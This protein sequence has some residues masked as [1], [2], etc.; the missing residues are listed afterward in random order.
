MTK[1][2]HKRDHLK[3]KEKCGVVAVWTSSMHASYYARRASASLQHRGQ[4][5]AGMSVLNPTGKISTHKGMGLV[6]HV[7]TEDVL[8]KLGNGKAAIAQNRYGTFGKSSMETAQPIEIRYHKLHLVL[9]H[10]G[11]IPDVSNIRKK[12]DVGKKRQSDTA[13]IAFLI[14]K[15]RHKYTS[16]EETLIHVLP[17]FRGA[18]CLVILTNDGSLFGIRDPYGIRPLCLGRLKDGWII[19]SESA[20][21]DTIGAEFV[22]DVKPGEIIKIDAQGKLHSYFFGEPK[23]PQNCLFEYIYFS[24]PDSFLNGRRVRTGREESGRLLGK[25]IKEKK[26]VPDVIVPTFDSGYPA[27]KGVAEILKIPTVDAITTSHYVGRT[28][29]QPG[30]SNR[31]AAVNGKHNIIPDD[32][33]GKK[34]V[35]VDD[36]GV[37]LTT[38]TALA[39]K[40]KEAG[41]K[42]IYI[43]FA[44]PPVV[45]QCDLGIDMRAIKELPA[46]QFQNN[47]LSIL[48]DKIA[49]YVGCDEVIYLPIEET[50]QAFGG[51]KEDFYWYT[52]G[53]PH[54]IRGTQEIFPKMKKKVSE[55]LKIC[56]FISGKGTFVQD[57][58]DGVKKGDIAAEI[59]EVLSNKKDAYGIARA[60][61]HNIPTEIISYE[62]KLS[63]KAARKTYEEKLIEHVKKLRPNVILLSNW[64]LI[65][66]D[67]FLKEMQKLEIPVINHHPALLTNDASNTVATSRGVIPVLRGASVWEETFAKKLPLSGISVH[68][69]LPGDNFDVG[70]VILKAE[71]RIRQDDTFES[72]RKRMDEIEHMLLPAAMKRIIHVMSYNLNI[73]KGDFPW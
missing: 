6:P 31:I 55:K 64:Q 41:A 25:R 54:P 35:I 8:K 73:S 57:I 14:T 66:G 39:K 67:T 56:V 29:I 52:F 9:G 19:A 23:R 53:G 17:E 32:I 26:I 16:W 49:N 59:C 58:I 20:A 5:S 63:D 15:E 37:R 48:E 22:R 65:L 12:F 71:V 34:V 42:E 24:R 1:N 68:Q 13:L 44:S 62:G 60:K 30:Q 69:V 51:K 40:F 36:S 21:L 4:E 11:N 72:W 28:F 61:N 33:S 50:A 43:A 7:L 18:Y 27:A 10:N 2:S 38:S 70:P 45:D 46:A 3:L 47:T